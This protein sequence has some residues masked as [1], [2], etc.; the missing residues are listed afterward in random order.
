MNRRWPLIGVIT[1]F[2]LGILCGALGMRIFYSYRFDS[3]IKGKADAR[4]EMLVNRLESKLKLDAGQMAQV[5]AIVHETREGIAALRRQVR[6]QI[7][8]LI[9][10]AH[11]RI[12][13]ILTPEQREI[14][15]KLVAE[16]KE[17]M[18]DRGM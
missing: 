10:K 1:V 9:G 7:E 11:V 12:T 5:R 14:F 15:E 17:K 6:P 16:R 8:A 3:I 4:E 13:T 18:R 2:V